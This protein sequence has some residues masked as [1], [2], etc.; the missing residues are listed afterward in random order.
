[1]DTTTTKNDFLE[2]GSGFTQV[3]AWCDR[4]KSSVMVKDSWIQTP[5]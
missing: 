2:I 5:F 1:L 3:F 4:G